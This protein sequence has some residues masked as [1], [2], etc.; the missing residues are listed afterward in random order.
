M[1]GSDWKD[2]ERL[3]Q[4]LPSTAAPA[5]AELKAKAKWRW[6]SWVLIA[7]EILVGVG[8]L[9]ACAW[10][11]MQP[12]AATQAMGVVA[13]A[14]AIAVSSVSIWARSVAPAR[15]EEPVTLAVATAVRRAR[16]G[17]RLAIATLWAVCAGVVFLAAIA[18]FAAGGE[19]E[20]SFLAFG[21]ALLWLAAWLAGAMF[22]YRRRS[23][24]LARLE[25][26]AASLKQE[27]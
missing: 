7:G 4:S 12:D 21:V 5:V 22:Y 26:I 17:T 19:T 23:A 10:L 24:D 16:I 6:A 13:L 2:L 3:W 11:I 1:S 8:A 15:A 25:A 14:F 9:V 18:F 27:V 20:P